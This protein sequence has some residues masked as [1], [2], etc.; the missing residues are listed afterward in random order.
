MIHKNGFQADI[1]SYGTRA[2]KFKVNIAPPGAIEI[3]LIRNL[4]LKEDDAFLHNGV[5]LWASAQRGPSEQKRFEVGGRAKAF[6]DAK[7]KEKESTASAAC[8]WRPSWQLTVKGTGGDAV[9]GSVQE[10]GAISWCQE[11][12]QSSFGRTTEAVQ[13]PPQA[14]VMGLRK[15]RRHR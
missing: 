10:D 12:L 6:L 13:K 11:S 2:H 5:A 4:H 9:L 3:S 1:E 14:V 15:V 7:A 8:S